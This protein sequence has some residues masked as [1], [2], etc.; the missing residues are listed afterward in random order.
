[1]KAHILIYGFSIFAMFFGS[2]NLV[3]P[4]KIGIETESFWFFSF[5]GLLFTGI[6]LPFLGLF[7][8]ILYKGNY[9]DF[10][11]GAGKY[12]KIVMP[13][14]ILSLLGSFGVV[15][16]CI[17]V[18]YGGVQ[19]IVPELPLYAFSLIFSLLCFFFCLNDKLMVQSIGKW[20]TPIL[21]VS[22]VILILLGVFK[23]HDIN[24]SILN[25]NDF[26]QIINSFST[27]FTTGYETMDLL[28]AFFF[29]SLVFKQLK[30][31]YNDI[32]HKDVRSSKKLIIFAMKPSILGALILALTYLGLVF[33]GAHYKFLI[34]DTQPQLILP[35]IAYHIIGP[36]AYIVIS[37]IIILSCLTTAIALN[38]IYAQ[39]ILSISYLDKKYFKI[40]LLI[41]TCISYIISLLDFNGISRFLAPILKIAYPSLIVLT[42]LSIFLYDKHNK[43][44]TII[45]YAIILIMIYIEYL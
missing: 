40:I 5:I 6:I 34:H 33:L 29:S 23:S 39:Y 13:L 26:T 2:G 11:S 45:F 32:Y 31:L 44:K 38:S 15:P 9:E 18:A 43:I 8:V 24:K 19:T 30:L 17:I 14:F 16:R 42:F 27:G 28:A 21:L 3:F 22:L 41:S 12:T 4:L 37:I 7:V 35:I 25:L 36:N 10:F 1:M 20:L